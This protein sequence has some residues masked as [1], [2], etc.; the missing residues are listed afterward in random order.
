[1]SKSQKRL[2][3]FAWWLWL[4]PFHVR[5]SLSMQATM[6]RCFFYY[7]ERMR[8][9]GDA[10]SF[11]PMPNYFFTQDR[12]IDGIVI[13]QCPIGIYDPQTWPSSPC[14]MDCVDEVAYAGTCVLIRSIGAEKNGIFFQTSIWSL[15]VKKIESTT[16]G[17]IAAVF[18]K[19]DS[20]SLFMSCKTHGRGNPIRSFVDSCRSIS[21]RDSLQIC[22][23]CV[24]DYCIP[25]KFQNFTTEPPT[26]ASL[27]I[28]NVTTEN[29]NNIPVEA[30]KKNWGLLVVVPLLCSMLLV[31]AV[32]KVFPLLALKKTTSV[33]EEGTSSDMNNTDLEETGGMSRT[34][35]RNS[36][37]RIIH[38]LFGRGGASASSGQNPIEAECN[39][40]VS[41]QQPTRRREDHV[42]IPT[43]GAQ[44]QH[45]RGNRNNSD[46]PEND[47][48]GPAA[49]VSSA[50]AE[51]QRRRNMESAL[52]SME[53]ELHDGLESHNEKV[54]VVWSTTAR[55]ALT[56][57]TTQKAGARPGWVNSNYHLLDKVSG[58]YYNIS[59]LFSKLAFQCI[60]LEGKRPSCVQ[61]YPLFG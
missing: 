39:I 28:H 31:V 27:E 11:P 5:L 18:V 38:L 30:E 52:R 47:G 6:K 34:G 24:G 12:D 20:S 14:L 55:T 3:S 26:I 43:V 13:P 60:G 57:P 1:M 35:L 4:T 51:D 22:D 54:H 48:G 58:S 7:K 50:S 19:N 2:L 56:S 8:S 25:Q 16:V 42:P 9:D 36:R 10:S 17:C 40:L 61:F 53:A 45:F 33:P 32:C 46:A 15:N 41:T 37:Y 49:L 59:L 29:N 44:L 21:P 23:E